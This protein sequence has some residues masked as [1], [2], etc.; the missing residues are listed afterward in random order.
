MSF[1]SN[2]KKK[3]EKLNI[4]MRYI[5][6]MLNVVKIVEIKVSEFVLGNE[7]EHLIHTCTLS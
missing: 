6:R 3:R 4:V 5:V 1:K 2:Y 7:R